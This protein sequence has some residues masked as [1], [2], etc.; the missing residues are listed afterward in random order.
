MILRIDLAPLAE[1]GAIVAL[2]AGAAFFAIAA[3][4]FQFALEKGTRAHRI[5]GYLWVSLLTL[6]ATSSFFIHDFRW[7]GP[8]SAIHLLSAYTLWSLW[9]AVGHARHGRIDQHRQDMVWIYGLALLLTGLF[10]LLPGRTMHAVL[11]GD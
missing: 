9:I 8:F 6:V 3:G 10:T 2:H 5:L 4:A 11:I 7:F 1:A